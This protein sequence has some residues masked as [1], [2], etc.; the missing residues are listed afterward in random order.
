M[1]IFVVASL[2]TRQRAVNVIINF[3]CINGLR[4]DVHKT[5]ILH[6]LKLVENKF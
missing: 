1:K 3:M 4:T 6:S 2:M 5:E